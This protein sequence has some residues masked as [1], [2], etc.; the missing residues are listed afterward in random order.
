MK[1]TKK[2]TAV[3]VMV[4]GLIGLLSIELAFFKKIPFQIISIDLSIAALLVGY[5]MYKKND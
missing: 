4:C 5:L 2:A 1:I 3:I